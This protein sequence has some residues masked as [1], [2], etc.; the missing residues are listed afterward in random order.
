MAQLV[1]NPYAMWETWIQSLGWED[2]LEK[3]KPTHCSILAW[4]IPWTVQSV[5]L[6]RVGHDGDFMIFTVSLGFVCFSFSNSCR[7]WVRLFISDFSSFL[8]QSCI[9]IKLPL[10]TAFYASHG[11]FLCFLLLFVSQLSSVTQ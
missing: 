8:G 6:Q 5:G 4:R 11:F 2:P 9:T 3:G 7:W 1:K 10:R